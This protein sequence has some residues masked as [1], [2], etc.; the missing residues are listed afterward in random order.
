MKTTFE[1]AKKLLDELFGEN[2]P[3]E[4]TQANAFLRAAYLLADPKEDDREEALA[5]FSK[6]AFERTAAFDEGLNAMACAVE[7]ELGLAAEAG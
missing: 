7:L 3:I 6:A 4:D 1:T 2:E 5:N